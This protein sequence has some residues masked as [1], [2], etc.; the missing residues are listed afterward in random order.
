MEYFALGDLET[1]RSSMLNEP[2]AALI[3]KQILQGLV[4]MHDNNFCDV[5]A[6]T[7][8]YRYKYRKVSQL[9]NS[10]VFMLI[11]SQVI[12]RLSNVIDKVTVVTIWE[13]I[14][15]YK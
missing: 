13:T 3:T 1:C 6:C 11:G 14:L 12:L 4:F 15:K 10:R 9:L 8:R 2:E 7:L 5:L